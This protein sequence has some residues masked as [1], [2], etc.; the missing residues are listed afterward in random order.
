MLNNAVGYL[1]L[2][3]ANR[4]FISAQQDRLL[5]RLTRANAQ[6]EVLAEFSGVRSSAIH[7]KLLTEQTSES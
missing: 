3:D 7:Q 4:T 6:F 5:A 1:V 2:L